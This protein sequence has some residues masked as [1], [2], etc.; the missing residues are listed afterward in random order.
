MDIR[1]RK[2]DLK[3]DWPLLKSWNEDHIRI[4]FPEFRGNDPY[5]KSIKAWLR[6]EPEGQMMILADGKEAGCLNLITEKPDAENIRGSLVRLHVDERF[7]GKGIGTRAVEKTVEYF[8]KKGVKRLKLWVTKSNDSA[9]KLY[10]NNG[11]H[12]TRYQ[13][14]REL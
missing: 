3:K 10:E 9:V 4:N 7:R 14:E 11:F 8:D 13:M 6:V 1:F 2:I 5:L 12:V